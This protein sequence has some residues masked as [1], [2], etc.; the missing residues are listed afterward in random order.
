[1]SCSQSL[2]KYLDMPFVCINIHT[3]IYIHRDDI[4]TYT[5]RHT[6]THFLSFSWMTL[7]FPC[8]FQHIPWMVSN[9]STPMLSPKHYLIQ[10]I[11]YYFLPF[12][13]VGLYSWPAPP[14]LKSLRSSLTT[15]H[16]ILNKRPNTFMCSWSPVGFPNL[17]PCHCFSL[18]V[19]QSC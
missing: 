18:C 15:L 9:Y 13:L 2:C 5:Y 16:V 7:S 3:H 12:T 1:M 17:L 8:I 19:I 11:F 6:H 10:H 14:F 4:N